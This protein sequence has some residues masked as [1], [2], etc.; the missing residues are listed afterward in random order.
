MHATAGEARILLVDD[1]P[2]A[3]RIAAKYLQGAGCQ[4]DLAVS[5]QEAVTVFASRPYDLVLMD[6][7]MPDMDGYEATRAIRAI[8]RV[9]LSQGRLER[10]A[11]PI[12]ALTA[13]AVKEDLDKCLESGM[14]DFVTKPLGRAS[15]TA[16]VEKWAAAR[17]HG[18][19]AKG[20]APLFPK[21]SAPFLRSRPEMDA[22]SPLDL[23]RALK[24][25]ENDRQLLEEVMV[26]FVGTVRGRLAVIGQAIESGDADVIFRE[27]HAIQ[28]GAANLTACRLSK[29]AQ[30][31]E[32]IGKS[33][34]L[35]G[36]RQALDE[37]AVEFVRL[38]EYTFGGTERITASSL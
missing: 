5:G 26:E 19:E 35:D 38:D 12:V 13:H 30:T 17:L 9:G 10:D 8:E 31:L 20:D 29:A 14:N 25:F 28:G 7:Q 24:E 6:V 4:V 34:V 21:G 22:G 32:T 2:V 15:L 3:R 23:D 18:R 36:G 27:A 11:V 1:C 33:G 37:L 16:V